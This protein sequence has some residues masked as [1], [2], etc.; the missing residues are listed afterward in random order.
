MIGSQRDIPS[1][2]IYT[3]VIWNSL[4]DTFINLRWNRKA[5]VK[6]I[7]RRIRRRRN[8]LIAQHVENMCK[9]VNF[10]FYRQVFVKY[11]LFMK[12]YF[13]QRLKDESIH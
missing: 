2:Q 11:I 13:A 8:V 5:V 7:L 1:P 6:W 4:S 9:F 3:P 12:Y 10:R